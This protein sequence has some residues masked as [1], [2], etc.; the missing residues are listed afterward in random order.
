MKLRTVS[1]A[2]LLA[3]FSLG[4]SALTLGRMHGA[5]WIG[6]GLDLSVQVQMDAGSTDTSL[7]A[8]A[9]VFYADSRQESARIRIS[10]EPG[11]EADAVLLRIISPGIIDEPVV[12][13]YL[14]AGC[15][16]K[17]T[18][19]YVL[20][21][22]YPTD[23]P[24]PLP[25]ARNAPEAVLPITPLPV[26]PVPLAPAPVASAAP[27]GVS[28]AKPAPEPAAVA[29]APAA[30]AP[31]P[32][33]PRNPPAPTS[34][35]KEKFTEPA[36]R[37]APTSSGRPRLKLDVPDVLTERAKVPPTVTT[38]AGEEVARETQR[39]EQ[40]QNDVKALLEQSAKNDALLV[41]MRERLEKAES[42]RVPVELVYALA[43]LLVLSLAGV[44]F[45]WKRPRAPWGPK[46]AKST[47]ALDG[48]PSQQHIDLDL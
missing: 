2:L 27:A 30:K 17:V 25:P 21:A 3:G 31:T 42:E 29:H 34:A 44:A 5:A 11:A 10:Q 32:P 22:D 24:T 41:A 9:D 8:E 19:R 26:S 46:G 13:V 16:Q 6:H 18:R 45:L 4:S 14:K 43:G 40:M 33:A 47:S 15:S 1:V 7:C 28:P 23:G 12:T 20:L 48:H 38:P 35:P 39:M 37:P 36:K